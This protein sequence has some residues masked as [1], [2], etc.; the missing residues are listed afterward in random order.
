MINTYRWLVVRVLAL[1]LAAIS[2]AL[3]H[4][5]WRK[6]S[7]ARAARDTAVFG[8][9]LQYSHGTAFGGGPYLS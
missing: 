2:V 8:V 1:R 4:S 9:L 7:I 5:L 3:V 6:S